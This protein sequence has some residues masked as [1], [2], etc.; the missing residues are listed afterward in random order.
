M[1]GGA[2]TS[3]LQSARGLETAE[4]R[5]TAQPS[6][7]RQHVRR[8]WTAAPPLSTAQSTGGRAEERERS[9][10]QLHS[11]Q[12]AA[13]GKAVQQKPVRSVQSRGAG[14]APET[15]AA[16]GG[17]GP[18]HC[19]CGRRI[20]EAATKERPTPADQTVAALGAL[21]GLTAHQPA[22]GGAR[23]ARKT[24][25]AGAPT[26]G[27]QSAA[28]AVAAAPQIAASAA[29]SPCLLSAAAVGA[30]R[31]RPAVS[32]P[33]LSGG[34]RTMTRLPHTSARIPAGPQKAAAAATVGGQKGGLCQRQAPRSDRRC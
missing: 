32:L 10:A 12:R 9:A 13:T 5:T 23:P 2:P 8:L 1:T 7:A 11:Q 22:T 33:A 27:P 14:M 17:D 29:A 18:A 24:Q 31:C 26:A 19:P 25:P 16:A 6:I 4:T 30:A 34:H 20:S 21:G 28:S 15:A 3:C